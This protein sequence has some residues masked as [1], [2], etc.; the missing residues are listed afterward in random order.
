MTHARAYYD[1]ASNTDHCVGCGT[2][3]TWTAVN[4]DGATT[5]KWGTTTHL[6]RLAPDTLLW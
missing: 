6:T 3:P 5:T 1:G 2:A 4:D